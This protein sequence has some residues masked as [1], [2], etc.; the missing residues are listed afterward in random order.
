MGNYSRNPGM[1]IMARAMY[2]G[3]YG[4]IACNTYEDWRDWW[5]LKSNNSY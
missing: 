2:A 5:C 3:C 1:N 4:N